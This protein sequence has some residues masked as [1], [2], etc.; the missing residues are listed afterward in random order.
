MRLFCMNFRTTL[1]PLPTP[2][3][4]KYIVHY[5]DIS[6]T[7]FLN[8][9]LND[10]RLSTVAPA[11]PSRR[12]NLSPP[13]GS[14]PPNHTAKEWRIIMTNEEMLF[15]AREAKSPEEIVTFA[16]ENGIAIGEEA[17]KALFESLKPARCPTR[18]SPRPSAAAAK[19]VLRI[20]SSRSTATTVT[21]EWYSRNT[22]EPAA[23]TPC[24]NMCAQPASLKRRSLS[25]L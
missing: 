13:T 5:T 10:I 20:S 9:K 22:P 19:R 11:H 24:A 15:K 16:K 8:P 3:F 18:S 25:R 6:Q 17:A 14:D 12:E 1:I 4:Q 2:I 23:P 7:T 21:Q